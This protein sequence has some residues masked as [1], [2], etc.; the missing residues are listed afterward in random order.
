MPALGAAAPPWRRSA[1]GAAVTALHH[2]VYAL[3]TNAA[4]GVLESRAASAATT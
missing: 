2:G 1:T 3:T 4:Y